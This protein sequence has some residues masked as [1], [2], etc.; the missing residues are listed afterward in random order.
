[1]Y[2]ESTTAFMPQNLCKQL[3]YEI[4]ELG[5][6]KELDASSLQLLVKHTAELRIHSTENSENK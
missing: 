4:A 1:M 5:I 3:K 6:E 2:F